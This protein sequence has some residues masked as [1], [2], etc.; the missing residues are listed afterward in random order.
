MKAIP[1]DTL[2]HFHVSGTNS[3]AWVSLAE[4]LAQGGHVVP[5]GA[6]AALLQATKPFGYTLCPAAVVA[7][8]SIA[9]MQVPEKGYLT[10]CEHVQMD[11]F[12]VID[13]GVS[14]TI[15]FYRQ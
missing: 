11:A 2:G 4:L 7:N 13:S 6:N 5:A 14:I 8:P 9:A 15:Q 3:G 10:L 12:R 1:V